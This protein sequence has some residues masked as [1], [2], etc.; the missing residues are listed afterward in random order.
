VVV[1]VAANNKIRCR[2]EE[3]I[4]NHC[5]ARRKTDVMQQNGAVHAMQ[6]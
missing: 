5:F 1:V 4:E 3:Y 2:I 6:G